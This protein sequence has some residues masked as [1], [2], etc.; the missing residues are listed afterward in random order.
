MLD[1][2]V[3]LKQRVAENRHSEKGQNSTHNAEVEGSSPSLTT[4]KINML[5]SF[6][7]GTGDRGPL[8]FQGAAN[9]NSQ[10]ADRARYA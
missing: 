2:S 7:L 4:N 10:R 5:C 3:Q 8:F 9:F 6:C 1:C